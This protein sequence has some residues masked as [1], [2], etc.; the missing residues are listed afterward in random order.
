[1]ALKGDRFRPGATVL[2]S[3]I[4]SAVH[5][6]HPKEDHEVTCTRGKKFPACRDCGAKVEFVLMH[7]AKHVRHHEL[8]SGELSVRART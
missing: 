2:S 5:S 7:K 1:M 3:G 8:F 6:G 4:Y